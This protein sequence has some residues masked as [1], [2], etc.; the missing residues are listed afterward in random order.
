[1]R[2]IDLVL[3]RA[4]DF[5][6]SGDGFLARCPLPEHGKGLG[7]KSPSVSVKEGDDGRAL[8][9]CLGGCETEEVLRRWGLTMGDLFESRNGHKGGAG[10]HIL[11]KTGTTLQ[12]CSLENYSKAKR[13]PKRFLEGLGVTD[14]RY[15]GKPAIRISYCNPDG[16]EAAIRFRAALEKSE[17]GRDGRFRWR[18]GDKAMLYGLERLQRIR[19]VG[20]VVLVEGESD[21]QTLW[22]HDIAALG[23]P[24]AANWKAEWA[25]L[26]EGIEKIYVIKEPDQGG[27]ALLRRLV[28]CE[29]IR[30]QLYVL[31]PREYEDASGL[32]L[33]DPEEFKQRVGAALKGATLYRELQRAEEEAASREAYAVCRY[34]AESPDILSQFAA[35]LTRLGVAGETVIAK[36]IYL[37]MVSRLLPGPVSVAVKG[38]SGGG[39]SYLAERV[40]GF[41]PDE[42]YYALTAMS[43]HALAYGEEP[44]SHRFL[45]LYEAA[46]MSGEFQTYLVRSLLSEGRVRY[47]TVEKTS[48]GMKP[49]LIE[50]EGPT[51]LIVTTTAV[52][53][54]PENETRLL[55]LTVTDTR[56]QT[57]NILATLADEEAREID[58]EPWLSLQKWLDSAEHRVTIPYARTLARM[59]PPVA[60]RLRRDFGAVLNLIR[61][62]A[63]LHQAS[64]S[65]DEHDCIVATLKDYAKVRELVADLVSA[66]VEATVP[67]TIRETVEL[68]RRL[69]ADDS[70]PVTIVKLAEEL[71]LDKSAAWRRVRA[72]IDRSYLKN[73]ED[74]KGRPAQL[75]PGD[76]M[77][78]D[79]EVLPTVEQLRGCTD[80]DDFEDIYHP[81]LSS[82]SDAER[83]GGEHTPGKTGSTVQRDCQEAGHPLDCECHDC[84]Y[85][86]PDYAKRYK[87]GS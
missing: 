55:S 32:Y 8:V 52:K 36:L 86:D 21:A 11:P 58:L 42:A 17:G 37:A 57:A 78:D 16:S 67:A 13:L 69:H 4:G 71:K 50:R 34:L 72:A 25:E 70:V 73:L 28:A 26:L 68:L 51:G 47:E 45:V 39:K 12:P 76:P 46:G 23:I 14:F 60:V 2:P 7:D 20:Y 59:V 44:L 29:S 24:G 64:R 81:P 41:F 53:L 85:P 48:E 9:N 84:V 19:K 40:L 54:H 79:L 18:K 62:H 75:V 31:E 82:Q 49:R 22:Y 1:M 3:D 10:S 74:R 15:M 66:G 80:A 33:D 65:K 56:E 30:E 5:R 38:P 77:P 35:T 27:E 63:M 6:K 83:G 61:A 43:E 87:G